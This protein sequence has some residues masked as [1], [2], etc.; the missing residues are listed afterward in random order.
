MPTLFSHPAA[1]LTRTWFGE[2]PRGAVIA[3]ALLS[4]LPDIDVLA[5]RLGIPYTSQWG[6]RGFTHSLAFALFTSSLTSLLFR[7]RSAVFAF[8]FVCAASHPL[9]DAMTNG[10]HGVALLWP[11]SA[12]RIFFAW[13]PI[14][15][16]PIGAR[17]FSRAFAVLRSEVVCVWG[18]FAGAGVVGWLTRRKH[19]GDRKL[20]SRQER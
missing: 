5:F 7:R 3:G 13:R 9:L 16:S 18:P 19:V 1:A 12:E 8:L 4:M 17:F 2:L 14:R 11:F 20:E 15:V 6:H 10:G